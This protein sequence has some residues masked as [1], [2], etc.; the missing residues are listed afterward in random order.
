MAYEDF[1][2]I[3][4]LI[5]NPIESFEKIGFKVGLSGISVRSRILKMYRSGFIQGMYSYH[6][7]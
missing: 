1:K 4:E 6:R 5:R 2:I 7:R 3:S